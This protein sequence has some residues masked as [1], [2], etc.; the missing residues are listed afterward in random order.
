MF[1]TYCRAWTYSGKP[2]FLFLKSYQ[3]KRVNAIAF[4]IYEK[5]STEEVNN[6]LSHNP[7]DD[8]NDDEDDLTLKMLL[9][10]SCV[11]HEETMFVAPG[12]SSKSMAERKSQS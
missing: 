2:I 10:L 11:E 7:R 4:F 9:H 8:D 6:A 3:Q 1:S 12:Q 5:K